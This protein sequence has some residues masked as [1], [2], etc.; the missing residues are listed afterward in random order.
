MRKL[1]QGYAHLP[2]LVVKIIKLNISIV[3]TSDVVSN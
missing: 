1:T 3:Q 2:T